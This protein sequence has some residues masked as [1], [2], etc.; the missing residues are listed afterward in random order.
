MLARSH[1]KREM[2]RLAVTFIIAGIAR[3]VNDGFYGCA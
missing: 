1:G 2:D 3:K